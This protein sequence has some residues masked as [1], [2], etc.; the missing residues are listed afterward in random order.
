MPPSLF[1][2]LWLHLG[3]FRKESWLITKVLE[4]G[5]Q[6]IHTFSFLPSILP[7]WP[8]LPPA[9]G[10]GMDKPLL[11]AMSYSAWGWPFYDP[12]YHKINVHLL[13]T[14]MLVDT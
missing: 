12:I 13:G 7:P 1:V 5:M 2:S 10:K 6:Q 3:H 9:R 8:P 14:Q 11:T 4:I